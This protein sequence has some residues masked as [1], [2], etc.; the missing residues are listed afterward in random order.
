M[1][2]CCSG[3]IVALMEAYACTPDVERSS[4]RADGILVV[5]ERWSVGSKSCVCVW[6]V[7]KVVLVVKVEIYAHPL[8]LI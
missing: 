8:S 2:D 1:I 5:C 6:K 4:H 3:G 7:Y